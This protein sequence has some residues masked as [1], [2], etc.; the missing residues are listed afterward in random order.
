MSDKKN[1]YSSVP[2]H[3]ILSSE[4]EPFL[5]RLIFKN[6]G[7]VLIILAL[8]TALFGYGLTKVSLDASIEKYIPLNHE[9]IQ[10]YL[11]HKDEMKSGVADR[12]SVV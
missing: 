11:V 3:Y 7:I 9:Y 8:L 1:H 10:N 4:S 6:R 2:E 5:E 12:K